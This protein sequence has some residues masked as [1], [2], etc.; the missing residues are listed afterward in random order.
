MKK[1]IVLFLCLAFFSLA[2]LSTMA[3]VET[4]PVAT[5]TVKL[6]RP[7]VADIVPRPSEVLMATATA[8]TCA[9]VIAVDALHLRKGPSEKDIVLA[10]LKHGQVVVIVDQRDADWWHIESGVYSGYVRSSYLQ[11]SECE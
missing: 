7:T 10:W 8:A 5:E 6:V 2:C 4:A 1:T 9:R 11:E 3:V